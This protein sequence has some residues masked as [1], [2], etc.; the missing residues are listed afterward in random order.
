VYNPPW[1]STEDVR[2]SEK[3]SEWGSKW[4]FLTRFFPGRTANHLKNRWYKVLVK[5]LM[6]S[7]PGV[8]PSAPA[9]SE[10]MTFSD[11]WI[12]DYEEQVPWDDTAII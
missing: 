12:G 11:D 6:V 3:L 9:P 4:V 10:D 7:E 5:Q 1:T 2:L 8:M